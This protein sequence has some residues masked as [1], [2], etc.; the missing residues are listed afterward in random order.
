MQMAAVAPALGVFIEPSRLFRLSAAVQAF[1]LAV[2]HRLASCGC[3]QGYTHGVLS[4]VED[5]KVAGPVQFPPPAALRNVHRPSIPELT[6]LLLAHY[7][8]IR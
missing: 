7:T 5:S 4:V 8:V 1:L 2:E 3:R 6:A